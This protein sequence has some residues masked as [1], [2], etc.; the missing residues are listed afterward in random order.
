MTGINLSVAA[1]TFKEHAST[2]LHIISIPDY[3][4]DMLYNYALG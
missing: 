1:G 2:C 3:E 4:P